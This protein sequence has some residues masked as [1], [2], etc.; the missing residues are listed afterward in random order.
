MVVLLMRDIV[1]AGADSSV[2]PS[3]EV[4]AQVAGTQ[5]AEKEPYIEASPEH[6]SVQGLV[7]IAEKRL[8]QRTS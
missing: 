8:L 7:F 5:V 4:I 3:E 2:P 6:R 1:S